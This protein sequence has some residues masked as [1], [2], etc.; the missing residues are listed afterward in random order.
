MQI[1]AQIA[2]I[3]LLFVAAMRPT[4]AHAQETS[5]APPAP[6]FIH[7]AYPNGSGTAL[8][9]QI[10]TLLA[11]PSV[12]RAHWGIAVTT[13][14][15]TPLYGHDEGKLFRPASNNKIFTTATAMELLGPAKTFDTRIFGK[16]NAATGTITGDLTLVGGGDA[17]FGADDLPYK[18]R[19]E[20][21][22]EPPPPSQPPALTDL[23]SLV[24]QLVAKGVK[25]INGDIVGD[26]TLYPFEPYAESWAQD[27]QI[28]GFGA[29]V[30][31]LSITSNQLELVVT[32]GHPT[33]VVLQ[34]NVPYYTVRAEVSTVAAG[35][36]AD[37]IQ[38]ERLA[39]SRV[40][41]VY[42]SIAADAHPD[43]EEVAIADPAEYAAM[44]LHQMLV[45]RG[46]V[47]AGKA[48]AKHQKPNDPG[49]YRTEVLTPDPCDTMNI[50]GGTCTADCSAPSTPSGAML[51]S[52]TSAPLGEDVMLTNKVSQNL[53]AELFLHNLGLQ[54]ACGD[55]ST[56]DGARYIRANLLH[57]GVDPDD[58]FFLDGSGLSDH[59]LVAP[60]AT[61]SFLAY[62]TRQPWFPQWKASLPDAGDNGSLSRRFPDSPV[63]GHVFAKT[64][65]LG[66]SRALS[67]YLDAASGR[68]VIFSVMV[69]DHTPATS[70]DRTTMD[71]IV[72][73][74]AATQ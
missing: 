74:I 29:P 59:D 30:S 45:R 27:D 18:P 49:S 58:F 7:P 36:Q 5:P 64:G 69:D 31:A 9:Q 62:V 35:K 38:I 34:Q 25:R 44:A 48:R 32:P 40:I 22:S 56:L 13:L 47:V 42:G 4:S 26:D 16:L 39:G 43:I 73:A 17:N 51:A 57:A 8:G 1:S 70:A 11:D 66:E 60:R 72:T 37:G 54:S 14:D 19:S 61:A 71:K 6:A 55:G 2:L 10:E 67:G 28:W 63:K 46:I 21:A 20:S 23:K 12:S 24:D 52:H 33:K 50:A 65:T 41:R 53:H 15:G 3:L 68:T